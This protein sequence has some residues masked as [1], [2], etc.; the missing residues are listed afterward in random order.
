[1]LPQ[2]ECSE[3]QRSIQPSWKDPVGLHN[4]LSFS[5]DDVFSLITQTLEFAFSPFQHWPLSFI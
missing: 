3:E 5:S 2:K 4:E 1:M